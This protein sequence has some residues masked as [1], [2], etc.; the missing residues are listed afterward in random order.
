MDDV[1][2]DSCKDMSEDDDNEQSVD[3]KESSGVLVEDVFCEMHAGSSEDNEYG[4]SSDEV[5][6]AV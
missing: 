4:G 3:S 6:L 5:M 2:S 1:L